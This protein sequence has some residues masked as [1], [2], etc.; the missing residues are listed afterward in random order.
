MKQED[1][2]DKGVRI[3]RAY[4]NFRVGQ[5]IF[6]PSLLRDKLVKSGFV[7]RIADDVEE[8]KP[9]LSIMRKAAD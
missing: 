2:V 9:R 7:Q 4:S 6:P 5:V 8:A 3:T 1:Y